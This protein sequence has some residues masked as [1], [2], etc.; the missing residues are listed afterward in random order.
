M[1]LVYDAEHDTTIGS[2]FLDPLYDSD[3]RVA[4]ISG[5]LI[6]GENDEWLKIG[7]DANYGDTLS[8]YLFDIQDRSIAYTHRPTLE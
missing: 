4:F 3:G 2:E 1:L 5:H 6:F 7:F 8:Q